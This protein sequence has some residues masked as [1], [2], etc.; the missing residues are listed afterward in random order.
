VVRLVG[1]GSSPNKLRDRIDVAAEQ[2]AERIVLALDRHSLL[3]SDVLDELRQSAADLSADGRSLVVVCP[4]RS[5][6]G[7]LEGT[8]LARDYELAE[9][10]E[11]A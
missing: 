8:G 2:G 10:L 3:S 4:D 6:R 7:L 11:A 5:L 9:S 1:P